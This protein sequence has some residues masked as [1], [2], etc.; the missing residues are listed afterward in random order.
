METV[1]I[2]SDGIQE[3][4]TSSNHISESPISLVAESSEMSISETENAIPPVKKGR[5]PRKFND[6]GKSSLHKRAQALRKKY[7]QDELVNALYRSTIKCIVRKEVNKRMTDT[8]FE[9]QSLALLLDINA[10]KSSFQRLRNN[11]KKSNMIPPYKS[12]RS[13]KTRCM[14]AELITTEKGSS[15][16][17]Q[18]LVNHTV[19]RI[20]PLREHEGAFTM[21]WK[22][23]SDGTSSTNMYNQKCSSNI[24]DGNLF[25]VACVPLK[26]F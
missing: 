15:I 8:D 21:E 24:D 14:P 1:T 18:A 20:K 9:D 7:T 25:T 23:G 12:V 5:K 11:F 4:V 3:M 13:A 22:I 17:L 16:K 10:T 2:V 19:E 26:L 6:L